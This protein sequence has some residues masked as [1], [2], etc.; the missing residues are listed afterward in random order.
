MTKKSIIIS[1]L[2]LTMGLASVTLSDAQTRRLPERRTPTIKRAPSTSET[3][4]PAT[5]SQS[6]SQSHTSVGGRA[7]ANTSTTSTGTRPE[8]SASTTSY[9]GRGSSSTA[10]TS[11]S[12]GRANASTSTSTSG[13]RS[14]AGTVSTGSRSGSSASTSSSG[15]RS[16]NPVTRPGT[17]STGRR[18]TDSYVV[19][20][21]SGDT[22]EEKIRNGFKLETVTKLD[23]RASLTKSLPGE[24]AMEPI[25]YSG[26]TLYVLRT[27]TVSVDQPGTTLFVGED[28]SSIYPGALVYC[29][30]ELANGRPR[31]VDLDR[32]ESKITINLANAGNS[33]KTVVP[34]FN[35]TH[36]AIESM[37][38]S[39]WK[40]SIKPS[41][42][43]SSKGTAY[44]S[45]NSM[46]LDLNVDASFLGQ[47]AKVS[48]NSSSSSTNITSVVDYTQDYYKVTLN[49][50][51]DKSKYFAENVTWADIAQALNSNGPIGIITSVTYG[52][53]AYL[54]KEYK[55]SAFTL[56]GKESAEV[57]GQK[58]SS[59]QDIADSSKCSNSWIY[60]GGTDQDS[61]GSILKDTDKAT[62]TLANSL[63]LKKGQMGI[64]ISYTV[65]YLATNAT[66]SVS[67]TGSYTE[68]EYVAVPKTVHVEIE[69]TANTACSDG[70]RVDIYYNTMTVDKNGNMRLV[71]SH[72]KESDYYEY[73]GYNYDKTLLKHGQKKSF[74]LKIPEGEYICGNLY[75]RI[76]SKTAAGQS[77]HCK[78]SGQIDPTVHDG[79]VSFR[80]GGSALAGGNL[81]YNSGSQDKFINSKK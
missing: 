42:S 43:L 52:R 5:E 76:F 10:N 17:T 8:S 46:A 13:G 26:N 58:I 20:N 9:G 54:F 64:P 71:T 63:T 75:V 39:M 74:D 51:T 16:G 44:S 73:G 79:S 27:K 29:D 18:P 30:K 24:A 61:A 40:G 60:I 80:I 21:V 6:E 31:L 25:I 19:S 65:K 37:L 35:N 38:T 4:T 12:G 11:S 33:S 28:F 36:E 57:L 66:C 68:T 2:I 78:M 23:N 32:G 69:C 14:N 62:E 53:R 47:K 49:Q 77:H 7:N 56:K 15:G 1:S 22:R 59:A 48:M 55:S 72:G 67:T 41:V 81:N 50:E 3:S 45:I 70:V 34:D